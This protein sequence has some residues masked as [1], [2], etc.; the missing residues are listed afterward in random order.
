MSTLLLEAEP[1]HAVREMEGRVWQRLVPKDELP[2]FERD[3]NVL[4]TKLLA[5]ETVIRVYSD[6]QPSPAFHAVEPEL[7]DVYFS[8]M[9]GV[10]R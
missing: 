9:G 5:G 7:H 2:A 1:L 3:Y 8:V 10:A 6:S 4:S